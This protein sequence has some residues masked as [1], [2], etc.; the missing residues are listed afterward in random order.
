[1]YSALT[2]KEASTMDTRPS[3]D[4]KRA[5]L[6]LRFTLGLAILMHGIVRLPHP[7]AFAD[8]MVQQFA[9]TVLPAAVVRPFAL[10]LVFAEAIIGLLLLLGLWTRWSLLLGAALI[11]ALVFGTAMRADWDTLAIQMLYALIYA[12]LLAGREYNSYSVDALIER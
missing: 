5:Y 2:K 8:G 10:G 11:S 1:M 9:E 12:A 3:L 7:R 6:M 4:R